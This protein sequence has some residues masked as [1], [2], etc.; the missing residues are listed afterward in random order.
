MKDLQKI[1]IKCGFK[2]VQT[3][4]QSGNVIFQS[5]KEKTKNLEDRLQ[6]LLLKKTGLNIPFFVY[7]CKAFQF[8]C[9]NNPIEKQANQSTEGLYIMFLK[10]IPENTDYT[11]IEKYKAASESLAMHEE[12]VYLFC[13]NGYGKTKLTNTLLEKIFKTTGTTRNQKTLLKLIEIARS[14][15]VPESE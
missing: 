12:A 2:N 10:N 13:P 8:I 15:D 4:I 1:F 3:Y 6:K 5:E 9:N 14:L 11:A 7:E